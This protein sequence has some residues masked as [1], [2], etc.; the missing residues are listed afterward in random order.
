MLIATSEAKDLAVDLTSIK[1]HLRIDHDEDDDLLESLALSAIKHVENKTG[2]ALSVTEYEW[3]IEDGDLKR[4]IP[5]YP[6]K[7]KSGQDIKG[8]QV[9]ASIGDTVQFTTS[10]SHYKDVLRP[11]IL[12]YVQSMYEASADDQVKLENTVN[13]ICNSVRRSMGL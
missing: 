1:N 10:I 11:A 2:W 8:G 3:L 4:S 5:L 9:S 13:A 12:L 7:I 6:A